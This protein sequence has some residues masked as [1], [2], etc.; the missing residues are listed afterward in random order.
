MNNDILGRAVFEAYTEMIDDMQNEMTGRP[1]HAFSD[2]FERKMQKVLNRVKCTYVVVANKRVR[3]ALLAGIIAIVMMLSTLTVIAIV[4]P[5]LIKRVTAQID[6]WR[7]EFIQKHPDSVPEQFEPIKP[8]VPEGFTIISE[9]KEINMYSVIYER[10]DQFI[11]YDQS[12]ADGL[13]LYETNTGE[14]TIV[15][16]NNVDMDIYYENGNYSLIWD[17]GIYVFDLYSNC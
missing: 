8:E 3:L 2:M 1:V 16:V 17:N 15:T 6:S 12:F 14:K 13:G 9:E 7:Y 10:G 11:Q 5:E 4:K